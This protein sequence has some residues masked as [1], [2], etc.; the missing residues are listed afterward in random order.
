MIDDAN[1]ANVLNSALVF[2]NTLLIAIVG[3][4]F[5]DAWREIHKRI[6]SV[7]D[8]VAGRGGHGERLTRLETL[9]NQ[10]RE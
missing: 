5:R 3:W 6:D 4:L 1:T 7:E 10:E 2:G 8:V 9:I